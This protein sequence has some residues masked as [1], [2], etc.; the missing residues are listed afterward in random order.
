MP[1]LNKTLRE[2]SRANQS[3]RTKS[4]RSIVRINVSLI[5]RTQDHFFQNLIFGGGYVLVLNRVDSKLILKYTTKIIYL[6][7]AL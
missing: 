7:W 5:G 4:H 6:N 1:F 2:N 3:V